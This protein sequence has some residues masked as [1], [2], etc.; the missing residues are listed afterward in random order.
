MKVIPSVKKG[1]LTN[2]QTTFPTFLYSPSRKNMALFAGANI[3]TLCPSIRLLKL[4]MNIISIG[5]NMANGLPIASALK[6]KFF[7]PLYGGLVMRKSKCSSGNSSSKKL[8]A[9]VLV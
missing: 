8:N 9:G 4:A 5:R 7:L 3:N 2:N 6:K 1:K